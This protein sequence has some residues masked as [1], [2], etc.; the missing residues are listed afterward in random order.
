MIQFETK[1]YGT[2]EYEKEWLLH[3]EDGLFGFQNLHD[4]LP[5]CMNEEDDNSILVL[6]SVED[7]AIAFVVINP[8]ALDPH[9][10]PSL[11]PE[12]MTYLKASDESELTY[13]VICVLKDNYLDNT[14]NMKCPLVFNTSTRN[15]MQV[16]L[17][18]DA[19]DF[20]TPLSAF[21]FE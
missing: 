8:F 2:L 6:Q 16:I 7:P 20:R 10:A 18:S 14:V 15:G 12:E 1:D 3:F 17:T 9:Y 5:L 13:Y 19:Y 11:T 4:Y 21:D